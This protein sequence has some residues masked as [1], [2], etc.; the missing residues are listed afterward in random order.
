MQIKDP[1]STI[2]RVQQG[3]LASEQCLLGKEGLSQMGK[4]FADTHGARLAK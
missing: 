3:G 4:G 1:K 2:I